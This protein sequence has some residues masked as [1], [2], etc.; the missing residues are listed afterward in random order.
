MS[1]IKVP[2]LSQKTVY[3][4]CL[5]AM[6]L[7]IAGLVIHGLLS[8]QILR[9]QSNNFET[10][11]KGIMT[12]PPDLYATAVFSNLL[13]E[14]NNSPLRII[15]TSVLS[16]AVLVIFLV[17]LLILVISRMQDYS[18]WLLLAIVFFIV[19]MFSVDLTIMVGL[20]SGADLT[21]ILAIITYSATG[22]ACFFLTLTI[23][24]QT[25]DRLNPK[26]IATLIVYYC[27]I[28]VALGIT[29]IKP[30]IN[31]FE[32]YI[33]L[34]LFLP[35]LYMYYG[36]YSLVKRKTPHINAA[37]VGYA[38]I[39][40]GLFGDA[41][42]VSSWSTHDMFLLY[43]ITLFCMILNLTIIYYH[44]V[45]EKRQAEAVR[46]NNMYRELEQ[47]S[48]DTMISQLQPHFMFNTLQAIQVLTRKDPV[49]ANKIILTFAEYLRNNLEF[50][51]I[52]E[53]V[54]F[55]QALVPAR[56][57]VD[58]EKIR[59]KNRFDAVYEIGP[60]AFN[61]PPFCIQPLI[62]NAVK[63]GVCRKPEGG[64][65]WLRTLETD[66]KYEIIIK[67]DGIGFD[68]K[69]LENKND[70][71]IYNVRFQLEHM[72]GGTLSIGS[73]EGSGTVVHISIP[74]K[75]PKNLERERIV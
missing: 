4:I 48:A 15:V 18:K 61:V 6:I 73:T 17:H 2:K 20:A 9:A 60:R 72:L 16:T 58:I 62:E 14:V 53:P 19:R 52:N 71:G 75:L 27:I 41:M 30:E 36:L 25:K 7:F 31:H 54:P 37:V 50:V 57:Y 67:D 8:G 56:C 43:P 64:S 28:L 66:E 33:R 10:G 68:V 59:F 11:V 29:F 74:K 22:L 51:K 39:I 13:D 32:A 1:K 21:L 26:F 55:E 42:Y 70:G 34:G 5:T 40:I 63:H 23:E 12:L 69:I 44:V 38:V 45:I 46:I 35:L 3:F 65:V 47:K 24:K 49:Q